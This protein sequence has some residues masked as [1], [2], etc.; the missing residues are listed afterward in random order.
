MSRS[1]DAHWILDDLLQS[2]LMLM[3]LYLDSTEEDLLAIYSQYPLDLL[4]D[5]L[6]QCTREERYICCSALRRVILEKS[7]KRSLN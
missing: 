4:L 3:G 7:V 6:D 1:P 5:L 2:E